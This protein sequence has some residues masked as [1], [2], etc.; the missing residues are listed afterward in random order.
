M[1][2]TDLSFLYF[3]F[4]IVLRIMNSI[5][6]GHGVVLTVENNYAV[7][8]MISSIELPNIHDPNMIA[9]WTVYDEVC[10]FKIIGK[11]GFYRFHVSSVSVYHFWC[12]KIINDRKWT[13]GTTHSYKLN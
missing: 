13:S 1:Q 12:D 5:S 3:Q 10:W 9:D 4:T 7:L 6:F 2:G 11:N 8:G